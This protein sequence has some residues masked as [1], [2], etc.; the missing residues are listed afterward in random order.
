MKAQY[1][2]NSVG[3]LQPQ[4]P[5]AKH[6]LKVNHNNETLPFSSEPTYLR[7]MLDSRVT[8]C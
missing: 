1:Y 6:Q 4:Q 5:K 7:R 2:K 3:S 8:Y